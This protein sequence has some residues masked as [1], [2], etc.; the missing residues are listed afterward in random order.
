MKKTIALLLCLMMLGTLLMA[1]CNDT[2]DTESSGGTASTPLGTSEATSGGEPSEGETSNGWVDGIVGYLG[3]GK[4]GREMPEFKWD[5]DTF[6]VLVYNNVKQT[7]YYS[8]E[9]E[10]NLYETTDSIISEAVGM[11]NDIIFDR[12]GVEIKAVLCDDVNATLMQQI[13][14]GGNDCADAAMP[15]LQNCTTLA[16][17]GNLYDLREFEKGG[18]IDLS[19]PWWEKNATESFS[20]A[21]KV[22]FCI[23]DMSIMQKIVSSA[24]MFNKDM[25]AEKYP[26]LNLYEEVR[27]KTWT[28]DKMISIS[29]EYTYESD[30]EDGLTWMD[31]W[32]YGG[33]YGNVISLYHAAGRKLISKNDDDEPMLVLGSSEKDVTLIQDL[34]GKLEEKNT[35]VLHAEEMGDDMWNKCVQ[36]FG[37][38]RQLFRSTAFS[39]VKK[40]RPFDVNFGLVPY[41]LVDENQDE[42]YTSCSAAWAY[43][44]VIPLSAPDPEFSAFMLDV[45]SAVSKGDNAAGLTRAYIEVV[46]K[47]KD[48]QAD[49][50]ACE[51]LDDYIFNNIIY[52]LGIIY[53]FGIDTMLYDM[54]GKGS[55]DIVSELDSNKDSIQA[56]IDDVITIFNDR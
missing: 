53:K 20:V 29:R 28:L 47:G 5:R 9:I 2:P 24:V 46:L 39:A 50:E 38:G 10:P 32:G 15:F 44:T 22:Y 31:T 11:R 3:D 33:T 7:T 51:I 26:D 56:K 40:V 23:G 18:Y 52:D 34:L 19:M 13:N 27:N 16:Q 55:T 8:E 45:M 14:A 36:I 43:G 30:D 37:E 6:N 42:Y 41:P 35:W 49:E 48:L 4:W 25:L 17:N 1:S 21:N 12:Y 54:V